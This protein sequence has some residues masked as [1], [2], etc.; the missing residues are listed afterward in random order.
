MSKSRTK[1]SDRRNFYVCKWSTWQYMQ[2][3]IEELVKAVL[4]A[5]TT[6]KPGKSDLS[7]IF[8]RWY[9]NADQK[10]CRTPRWECSS[11]LWPASTT[12]CPE[13]LVIV[14]LSGRFRQ[15]VLYMYFFF[16]KSERLLCPL[17]WFLVICLYTHCSTAQEPNLV[18]CLALP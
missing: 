17:I 1:L 9:F 6:V 14:F 8:D 16:T 4:I 15:V 5:L 7:T 12:T 11:I 13:Y 2:V 18:I 10:Y 3:Y